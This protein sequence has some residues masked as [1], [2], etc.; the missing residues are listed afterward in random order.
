MLWTTTEHKL[1]PEQKGFMPFEGCLEHN[2]LHAPISHTGYEEQ[3]ERVAVTWLDLTNAF[4]T[5]IWDALSNKGLSPVT[6]A[7]I[8]EMYYNR[9]TYL[10]EAGLM[11]EVPISKG[12]RQGC[13]LSPIVFNFVIN[14][15]VAKA[16]A[17]AKDNG[18]WMYD[19]GISVL[20]VGKSEKN[21]Q[22][23]LKGV[24]DEAQRLGLS[25]NPKKCAS[26]HMSGKKHDALAT[27][28]EVQGSQVPVLGRYFSYR[29][30]HT[31]ASS[32]HFAR[33]DGFN[34]RLEEKYS[35]PIKHDRATK[36]R[37]E[38]ENQDLQDHSKQ[39]QGTEV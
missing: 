34:D 8:A 37:G 25:F 31:K 14:S 3:P 27:R 5:T 12:V 9:T 21:L 18:Y 17:C 35:Q 26:L 29:N 7:R 4:N 32:E 22:L 30:K 28:F 15:M 1:S 16:G 11:S 19:T 13:P 6:V 10:T 39:D 24:C 20:V 23:F 38:R 2:Q 36:V 33:K